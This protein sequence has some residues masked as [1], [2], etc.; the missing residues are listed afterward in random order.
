MQ[1]KASIYSSKAKRFIAIKH[2]RL[3]NHDSEDCKNMRLFYVEAFKSCLL[4]VS[5][6][7]LGIMSSLSWQILHQ[8]A[9]LNLPL[10]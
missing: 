8:E 4:N 2:Q 9:R 3:E 10:L 5:K 6:Y 7:I 1:R